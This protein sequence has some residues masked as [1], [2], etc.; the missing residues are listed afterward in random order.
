MQSR[1]HFKLF[2]LYNK[3]Q[4]LSND[5]LKRHSITNIGKGKEFYQYDG[6]PIQN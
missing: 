2:F 4:N 5:D 1:M 3:M 6:I